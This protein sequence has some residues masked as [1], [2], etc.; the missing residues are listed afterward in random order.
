MAGDVN[1]P[2]SKTIPFNSHKANTFY[3]YAYTVMRI[4]IKPK[5]SKIYSYLMQVSSSSASQMVLS[6]SSN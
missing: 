2:V 1:G 3:N 6:L 4:Q 5:A